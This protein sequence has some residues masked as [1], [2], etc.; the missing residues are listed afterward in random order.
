MA[1][2][3]E[4]KAKEMEKGK[5]KAEEK[6]K[7]EKAKAKEEK[8]IVR[9]VS[10]DIPADTS[11]YHGLTFIKGISWSFSNAVCAALGIDKHRKVS[12]LTQDEIDKIT[13]FLKKPNLPSF[14]LNR[15]FDPETGENRHLILSNLDFQREFD[16]RREKKIKSLRGIRHILGQP[17]RGQRTRSHFRHGR[18]VGVQRSKTQAQAAGKK[19]EEKK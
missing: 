19:K 2:D 6:A 17:V 9:I 15:R 7:E 18:A 12:S 16:I 4:E 14:L 10:T 13:E 11:I 5:S 3:K 8:N 1:K